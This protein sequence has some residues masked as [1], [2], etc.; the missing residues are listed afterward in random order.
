MMLSLLFPRILPQ[1]AY[2]CCH[3][4]LIH[5][6]SPCRAI[7]LLH[8]T[9]RSFHWADRREEQRMFMIP[10]SSQ[11]TAETQRGQDTKMKHPAASDR[12]LYLWWPNMSLSTE[13]VI[14]N[15]FLIYMCRHCLL[16]S[17]NFCPVLRYG[18]PFWR[19]Q[20]P[21][22][23]PWTLS[24]NG[25]FWL[26]VPAAREVRGHYDVFCITP[27]IFTYHVITGKEHHKHVLQC[28]DTHL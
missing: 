27:E 16:C 26:E 18:W 15:C 14:G 10:A 19:I 2:A 6:W 22:L 11:E 20:L 12:R 17:T 4:L 28:S 13:Q 23:P 5:S 24:R 9:R 7:A 8:F 3:P 25:I 21:P 1:Q